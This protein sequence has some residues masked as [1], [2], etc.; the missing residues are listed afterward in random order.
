M[1]KKQAPEAQSSPEQPAELGR[2]KFL[3]TAAAA[4]VAVVG[5]PSLLAACSDTGTEPE[6]AGDKR[7]AADGP[8]ASLAGGR[9]PGVT[10][11]YML[12]ATIGTSTDVKVPALEKGTTTKYLQRVVTDVDRTGT[13]LAT[14]LRA[15]YKFADGTT[16]VVVVQD[17]NGRA[18][19]ARTVSKQSDLAYAMKDALA[20]NPLHVGVLRDSLTAGNAV[21]ALSK[22]S[23]VAFR[24]G[25]ASDYYGNHL[26]L[27][28]RGFCDVFNTTVA[29]IKLAST[30]RD[31]NRC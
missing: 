17:G 7:V 21:V 29:G 27:A 2:R 4:A 6:A 9:D 19:P 8:R 26:D 24:D 20:T 1:S 31:L 3:G 23:V 11:H 13:G 28:S 15:S 16:A 25:V 14:I 30:M 10:L 5:V 18:W 12:A 22:S